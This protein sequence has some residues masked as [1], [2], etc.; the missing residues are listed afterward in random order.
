[1]KTRNNGGASAKYEYCYCCYSFYNY[2]VQTN[3][4]FL[5]AEFASDD[6]NLIVQ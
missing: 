1:M 5:P 2:F 6:K 4:K 3:D